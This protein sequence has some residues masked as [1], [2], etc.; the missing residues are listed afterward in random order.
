MPTMRLRFAIPLLLVTTLLMVVL[1][2]L[3]LS[4]G[5]SGT[6]SPGSA[7]PAAPGTEA[8]SSGAPRNAEGQAAPA[9]QPASP[10]KQRFDGATLPEGVLAPPF[11]LTDQDGR[12]VALTSLRGKVVVLGFL[13]SRCG[14]TCILV[15]E[16]VRGALD[17]LAKPAAVLLVSVDPRAD[18]RAS[19]R[20]FL[21]RVSLAGR[22]DY[23][24]GT[25]RQ[26]APIFSAYSVKAPDPHEPEKAK[27]AFASV[28]LID[29]EGR[30][31]VRYGVEQLT[32][33]SLSHD[34][35]K[36]QDGG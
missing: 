2:I 26:L 31:R 15:A 35:R 14:A 21:K 34:I 16:Q 7:E 17:E 25:P 3:A 23:L 11:A 28:L 19:V 22:A 24:A 27:G 6:S 9:A 4:A 20:T 13:Y 1:V 5:G 33:E 18:T 8:P 10:S 12:Q 32:P 36:L 30:E 29:P